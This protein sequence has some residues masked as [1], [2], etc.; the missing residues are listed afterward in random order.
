MTRKRASLDPNEVPIAMPLYIEWITM[1]Y[2]WLCCF[3]KSRWYEDYE[4]SIK[5]ASDDMK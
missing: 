1:W 2:S 4:K 5:K 3:N